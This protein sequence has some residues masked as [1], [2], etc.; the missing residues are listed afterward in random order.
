MGVLE[1]A[2]VWSNL[3][4]L[5]SLGLTLTYITTAVPNFAQASFAIVGSYVALALLRSLGLHPYLSVPLTFIIGGIVGILTYVV[6]LKPLVKKKA[7]IEMLMIA[8]LAWD[9]ILFG[10]VGAFS[11]TLGSITKRTETLFVFTNIDFEIG[12]LSGRFIVSTLAV[13]LTLVGLYIL[14][15]KTKFGI[16]LRASMENPALAETMGINVENTRLFS[17][18]LSGALAGMAGSLLPFLQEIVPQTGNLVIVSVFAASIVG[19]LQNIV[20]A[21]VGGYVVGLSE[22]LVTYQLSNIFGPGVL[23]YNKVV[24]LLMMIIVILL[25]PE[26]ITGTKLWRRLE[27]WL[28]L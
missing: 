12:G 5:L 21:L 23:V 20:G 3:I 22:S 14:L 2:L 6:V 9:L 16:A 18:F 19:G 4:V 1:G 27:R 24:S 25:M 13:I 28:N 17:W 26:G 8:T 10:F 11:E 15:Y 7:S